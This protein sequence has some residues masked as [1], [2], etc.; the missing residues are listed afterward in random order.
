MLVNKHSPKVNSHI[1]DWCQNKTTYSNWYYISDF[2][3]CGSDDKQTVR[4]NVNNAGF[5][6]PDIFIHIVSYRD[7]N[8]GVNDRPNFEKHCMRGDVYEVDFSEGLVFHIHDIIS[9][10]QVSNERKQSSDSKGV[11][12]PF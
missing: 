10:H 4:K 5:G 11:W 12:L 7:K 3:N 9:H 2:P 8:T 1:I 6:S